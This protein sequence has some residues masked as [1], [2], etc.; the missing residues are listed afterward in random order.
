MKPAFWF[1]PL[2]LLA[3]GRQ[4]QRGDRPFTVAELLAWAPDLAAPK[5]VRSACET[6]QRKGLLERAPD[7]APAGQRGPTNP[8]TW[9]LTDEGRLACR[10]AVQ[11]AGRQA[12]IA[13]LKTTHKQRN[14]S[15]LYGRLWN[16]LRNRKQLTPEE[17]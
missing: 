12:R 17:A 8:Q 5:T 2:V 1:I 9:R 10:T 14:G 15:T 11:E 6:L 4:F 16:L 3:L 13:T 7:I